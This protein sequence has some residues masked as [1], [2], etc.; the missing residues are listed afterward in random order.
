MF[1]Y[2]LSL[3]RSKPR[4]RKGF[5]SVVPSNLA[6]LLF[7]VAINRAFMS[8]SLCLYVFLTV[9][10]CS[11]HCA[12]SQWHSEKDMKASAATSLCRLI[13]GHLS[14][15]WSPLTTQ[16]KKINITLVFWI[17]VTPTYGNCIITVMRREFR[18]RIYAEGVLRMFA[19]THI[20]TNQLLQV[21]FL[22]F[23]SHNIARTPLARVPSAA[24]AFNLTQLL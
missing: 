8:I 4:L 13:T 24:T 19:T 21:R 16:W 11:F 10:L 1:S 6:T 22:L 20:Y 9:P 12:S 14:R 2:P 3:K 18:W 7:S 15:R 17:R 23:P 5:V